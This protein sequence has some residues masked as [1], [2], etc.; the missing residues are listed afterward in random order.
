MDRKW[1]ARTV[2][3]CAL[4]VSFGLWF[5]GLQLQTRKRLPR[6]VAPAEPIVLVRMTEF[7]IV[8]IG[9]VDHGCST[10]TRQFPSYRNPIFRTAASGDFFDIRRWQER[11]FPFDSLLRVFFEQ[12]FPLI[13]KLVQPYFLS[14]FTPSVNLLVVRYLIQVSP[15]HLLK[16]IDCFPK[17][18]TVSRADG[19]K[20]IEILSELS[21]RPI[22]L[23]TDHHVLCFGVPSIRERQDR[24]TRRV[25][26]TGFCDSNFRY[27]AE[28][29]KCRL[30]SIDIQSVTENAKRE[31][32]QDQAESGESDSCLSCD[33]SPLKLIAFIVAPLSIIG[34]ILGVKMFD[35][36]CELTRKGLDSRANSAELYG[37]ALCY[38]AP[39]SFLIF[40]F[41]CFARHALAG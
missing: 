19:G 22:Q 14:R 35:R 9:T 34:L 30:F 13:D 40:E 21:V 36:S 33:F 27:Q 37:W 39:V 16:P 7:V 25:T 5:H 32:R 12:S 38:V 11:A 17:I 20:R 6:F 1:F 31:P 23:R 15:S 4:L 10:R 3:V 41:L 18:L 26:S 2:L 28:F 8:P 29:G 24:V